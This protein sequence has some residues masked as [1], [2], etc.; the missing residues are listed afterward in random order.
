MTTIRMGYI[1]VIKHISGL[2][3][4]YVGIMEKEME[5]QL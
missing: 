3:R 4:D 1:R 2:Y 5:L